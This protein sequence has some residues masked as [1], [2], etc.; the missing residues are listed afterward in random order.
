KATTITYT[1]EDGNDS[2]GGLAMNYIME[3]IDVTGEITVRAINVTAQATSKIY[4][5]DTSSETEPLVDDLQTGDVVTFAGMQTYDTKNMG[6][7][8]TLTPSGTVIDDGN[9]GDNYEIT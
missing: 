3:P 4:D 2:N 8:K 9:N 7:E 6:T 1:L 5:G